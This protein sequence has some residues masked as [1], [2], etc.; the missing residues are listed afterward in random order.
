M[1]VSVF[2]CMYV[3]VCVCCVFGASFNMGG[4]SAFFKTFVRVFSYILY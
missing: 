4:I 1:Y 2:V 3:C